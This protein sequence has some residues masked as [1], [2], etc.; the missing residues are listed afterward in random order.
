[1]KNKRSRLV[2]TYAVKGKYSETAELEIKRLEI[3]EDLEKLMN[4]YAKLTGKK[5]L[6][7]RVKVGQAP[8]D[9]RVEDHKFN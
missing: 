5:E 7:R 6:K 4:E 8:N 1:M 2:D 3:K 9:W